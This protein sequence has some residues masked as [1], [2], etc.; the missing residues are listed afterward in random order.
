MTV[1]RPAD[2]VEQQIEQKL[3]QQLLAKR[4][5]KALTQ[6]V[7]DIFG[8]DSEGFQLLPDRR[9]W[10]MF[11][12]YSV[13]VD[14]QGDGTGG[15]IRCLMMLASLSNTLFILE[16]PESNQHPGSLE[17]FALAVCKQAKRQEVQLLVSTHSRECVQFFLAAAQAA[18]ADSAV[19]HLRREDGVLEAN[20]LDPETVQTLQATGVDVRCLDLYG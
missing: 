16:E 1:F 2:A 5:D 12:D 20:R 4:A 10:A 18:N 3:W 15:A 7:N 9:L 8:L 17:R 11:P 19:F 14:V 13:P 6:M